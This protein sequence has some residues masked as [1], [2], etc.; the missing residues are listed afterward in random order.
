MIE[1]KV[2]VDGNGLG[3]GSRDGHPTSAAHSGA[4]PGNVQTRHV[5]LKH[6]A[7]GAIWILKSP[8]L[9]AYE[10]THKETQIKRFNFF[11]L[12]TEQ[13]KIISTW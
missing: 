9:M 1:E 5:A 8:K 3:L 4:A 7:S 10:G 2:Q 6:K 12:N 13:I 11:F